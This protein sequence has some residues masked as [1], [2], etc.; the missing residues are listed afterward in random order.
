MRLVRFFF[1]PKLSASS[2]SLLLTGVGEHEGG[3]SIVALV[4]SRA[5]RSYASSSQF[6]NS[7]MELLWSLLIKI[8]GTSL[9]IGNLLSVR[10]RLGQQK[11][12]VRSF[13]VRM[14]GFL[15]KSTD[16]NGNLC[17]SFYCTSSIASVCFLSLISWMK[18]NERIPLIVPGLQVW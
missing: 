12:F 1:V 7:I 8:W 18:C 9:S 17:S 2:D 14:T 13:T 10:S 11:I 4:S 5:S 6:T 16:G 3:F 15:S